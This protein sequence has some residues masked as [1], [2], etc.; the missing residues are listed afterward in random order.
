M[1]FSD[2]NDRPWLHFPERGNRGCAWV[3]INWCSSSKAHLY[4][5]NL[6]KENTLTDGVDYYI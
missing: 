2:V 1:K 6:F 4:S 5:T 3:A